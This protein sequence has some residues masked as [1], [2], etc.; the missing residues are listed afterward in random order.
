MS[1]NIRVLLIGAGNMGKAY[2]KVLKAQNVEFSTFTRSEKTAQQFREETGC[3]VI[4]G[5]LQSFLSKE[6]GR[7][8]H[9]INAVNVENLETVTLSLLKAGINKILVEKPLGLSVDSIAA[10]NDKVKEMSASVYV[11]YNRRYY[12]STAKA[13][14]IIK[15][16]GGLKSVLFEFT[17]WKTRIDFSRFPEIV[18]EKWLYANSSHVIDLAFYFAGMPKNWSSYSGRSNNGNEDVFVGSG[19]TDKNIYFSYASNWDAPGRWGVEL[20]TCKHRL[21]LRPM[22]KLAIQK[23][24]SVAVE[25]FPIDDAYDVMYKP[26]IYNEVCDFLSGLPSDKLKTID[27]QLRSIAVYEQILYGSVQRN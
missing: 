26:G 16:D 15:E 11:A 4:S 18:R 5:D 13:L 2:A 7:F 3:D 25:E 20:L 22:E 27:D 24:N 9:A 1:D 6:P 19:L 12:A 23:I 21:Y 10:L 17:E 14:E 8:S